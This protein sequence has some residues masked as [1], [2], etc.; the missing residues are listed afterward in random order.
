VTAFR[1]GVSSSSNWDFKDE[2]GDDTLEDDKSDKSD[3]ENSAV[4]EIVESSGMIKMR[5]WGLQC[6]C[7]EYNLIKSGFMIEDLESL[8]IPI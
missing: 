6:F 2:G 1:T 4:K 7:D 3:S 5:F 8:K